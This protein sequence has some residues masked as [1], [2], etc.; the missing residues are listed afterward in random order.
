MSTSKKKPKLPSNGRKR[1]ERSKAG[2]R[3]NSFSFDFSNHME[4]AASILRSNLDPTTTTT[5][6]TT[7]SDNNNNTGQVDEEMEALEELRGLSEEE[8]DK[9]RREEDEATFSAFAACR[10]DDK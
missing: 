3:R 9:G 4:F 5:V 2:K 1:K 7:T 10:L 8:H 6:V